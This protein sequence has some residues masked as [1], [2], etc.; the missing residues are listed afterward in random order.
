MDVAGEVREAV[1]CTWQCGGE[2]RWN[3]QVGMTDGGLVV[4]GGDG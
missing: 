1:A 4:S 3:W 2:G